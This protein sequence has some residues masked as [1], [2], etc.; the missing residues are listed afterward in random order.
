M[1]IEHI[2]L[3]GT[4]ESPPSTSTLLGAARYG[5]FNR[6]LIRVDTDWSEAENST[7]RIGVTAAHL[8]TFRVGLLFISLFP[9][10]R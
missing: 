7:T 4:R 10:L 9:Q 6:A 8:V 2:T 1:R 3:Y 5:S